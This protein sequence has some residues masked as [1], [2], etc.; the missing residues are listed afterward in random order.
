MVAS[1][2]SI[3]FNAKIYG[4]SIS[5]YPIPIPASSKKD[6]EELQKLR[7]NRVITKNFVILSID[8]SQ[9]E[10]L[11]KNIESIKSWCLTRWGL[12]DISFPNRIHHEDVGLEPGCIVVCVPNRDL[13]RDL[14]GLEQSHVQ[15]LYDK[16]DKIKSTQIWLMLDG[17]YSEIVAPVLTIA[18][19]RE[20]EEQSKRNVPFWAERGMTVL[21]NSLPKIR[22]FLVHSRS[23]D[24]APEDALSSLR[25]I[26][27]DSWMQ[28]DSEKKLDYDARSA[29]FTLLL[30]REFGQ[31]KLHEF[32][33]ANSFNDDSVYRVLGFSNT[34]ELSKKFSV[35]FHYL[36]EDIVG[37]KTP[38]EYLEIKPT[39]IY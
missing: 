38:D 34:T 23:S 25:D 26:E 3:V 6:P 19:L 17:D 2:L 1:L 4:Q 37:K 32:I 7:W 13:L 15:I 27:Q 20:F 28:L 14:I 24:V 35:Y 29:A 30:R 11:Q 36:N 31:N 21:N 10:H 39:P 8:S 22:G 5:S 16:N 12:G 18:C 9:G 33:F